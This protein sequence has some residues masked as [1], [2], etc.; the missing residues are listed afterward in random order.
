MTYRKAINETVDKMHHAK[1]ITDFQSEKM[2]EGNRMPCFYGLPKLHNPFSTFPSLRPI[3]SGS[4]SCTVRISEFADHFLKP[5]A[6]RSFS[7]VK[8]T[9]AFINKLENTQI[10]NLNNATLVS[11]NVNSL[12]PNIDHEE[13]AEACYEYLLQYDISPLLSKFLLRLIYLVLKCNTLSFGSRFFHQIKGTAMGTPM[14]VNFA[15]LFMIKF[16]SEMLRDFEAA[17]GIRPALWLRYIDDI[18]FIWT[19]DDSSLK[20]FIEF[21]RTYSKSK[22]MKSDITFNIVQNKS[23]VVFLDTRVKLSCLL[24]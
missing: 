3:C 16:E 15:N 12:Y 13:G 21:V 11:M 24:L 14:A 22:Q 1:L 18:F 10:K 6:Q 5:I 7:Y 4:N 2:K 19:E 20:R 17:N 8:D 9:T 23:S